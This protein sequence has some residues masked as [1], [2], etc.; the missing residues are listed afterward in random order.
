MPEIL[1]QNRILS[2]ER[3]NRGAKIGAIVG[4]G[5]VGAPILLVQ[6]SELISGQQPVAPIGDVLV[7]IAGA[8]VA[9]GAWGAAING[10]RP[11][12]R[13][14]QHTIESDVEV[15]KNL[16]KEATTLVRSLRSVD[17]QK[18]LYDVF[19][20][21]V[22][23]RLLEHKSRYLTRGAI[24]GSAFGL[25]FYASGFLVKGFDQLDR[26]LGLPSGPTYEQDLKT[27]MDHPVESIVAGAVLGLGIAGYGLVFHRPNLPPRG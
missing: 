3:A 16:T 24:L 1:D 6:V 14:V 12:S 26:L 27:I 13:L 2:K 11:T 8:A 5:L 20:P 9:G 15:L 25:S 23:R 4:A 10:F 17:Y 18:I 7:S 22:S 19:R 21:R